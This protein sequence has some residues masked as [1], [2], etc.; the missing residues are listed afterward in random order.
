LKL[1]IRLYI[2]TFCQGLGSHLLVQFLFSFIVGLGKMINFFVY[3]WYIQVVVK[4]LAGQLVAAGM[5]DLFL[6]HVFADRIHASLAVHLHAFDSHAD[7]S[8]CSCSCVEKKKKK[9]LRDSA[10][11]V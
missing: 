7:C 4:D 1:R 8:C 11:G 6:A 2:W 9:L 3:Q 5:L 10:V